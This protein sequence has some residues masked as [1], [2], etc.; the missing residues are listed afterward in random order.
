MVHLELM[1]F[2]ML[3]GS[4]SVMAHPV[5]SDTVMQKHVFEDEKIAEISG[6]GSC[7][8]EAWIIGVRSEDCT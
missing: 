6:L 1:G 2:D 3:L 8:V 5:I 4:E 7:V